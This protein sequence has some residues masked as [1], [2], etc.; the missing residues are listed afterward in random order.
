MESPFDDN[1]FT[2]LKAFSSLVDMIR[3][4]YDALGVMVL[5]VSVAQGVPRSPTRRVQ[6]QQQQQQCVRFRRIYYSRL[7]T[8]ILAF[9]EPQPPWPSRPPPT[10]L[11]Q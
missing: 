11:G 7:M 6:Q 4:Y 3:G 9:S 2:F 10:A 5:V 8:F 1:G